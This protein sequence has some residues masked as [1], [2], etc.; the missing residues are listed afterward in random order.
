[1][2]LEI[3]SIELYFKQVRILHGIYLKAET[4]YVTGILGSNGSGKSCLLSIIFGNLQPKYKCIRINN[5]LIKNIKSDN[6]IQQ[7]YIQMLLQFT[8]FKEN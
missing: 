3:D 4:G 6:P 1:M 2:I 8:F 7:I 5:K